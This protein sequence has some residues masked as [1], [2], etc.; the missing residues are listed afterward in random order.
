MRGAMK[1]VL[2]S[3]SN[4]SSARTTLTQPDGILSFIAAFLPLLVKD[5]L[6]TTDISVL[7]AR[8]QHLGMSPK[9]T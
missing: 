6:L 2:S 7:D 4:S 5:T 9:G 1:S 3:S 8:C